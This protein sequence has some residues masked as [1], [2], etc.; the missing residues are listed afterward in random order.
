MVSLCVASQKGGV[1]KTTVAL[2]LAFSLARRGLRTLLVDTDPAGAI[3]LSLTKKL[4]QSPGLAEYIVHR[5][6]LAQ[7]AVQ[8]KLPELQIL[9]VGRVAPE[10]AMGFQAALADGAV[11]KRIEREASDRELIIVDTPSGFGGATMGAMRACR[12]VLCPVQAEPIAARSVLRI[13]DVLGSLREKGA[14]TEVVGILLT[15]LQTRQASSLGVA[16]DL[17]ASLPQ[18]LLFDT[19]IPRDAVFLDASANGVPVGLLKRRPPPVA[20]VF[21]QLAAELEARMAI[22]ERGMS[23]EPIALVD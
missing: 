21:D 8:T 4:S 17:W 2:N 13:F 10:D 23:N 16:E 11:L 1:G 5:R 18:S 12:Y 19:S 22:D 9:T 14:N 6:P 15:M 20:M 7:L 3:G